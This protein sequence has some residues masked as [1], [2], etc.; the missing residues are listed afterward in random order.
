MLFEYWAYII[1]QV[2]SVLS[3]GT[4]KYDKKKVSDANFCFVFKN[5]MN[6]N[7]LDGS[8]YETL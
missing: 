6:T 8:Q 1:R 3:L 7:V 4:F 5:A 2:Y